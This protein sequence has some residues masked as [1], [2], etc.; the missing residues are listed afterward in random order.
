MREIKGDSKVN[1]REI[2]GRFKG[3]KGRFEEDVK[4]IKGDLKFNL[5]EIRGRFK[6]DSRR[7]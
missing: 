2:Q 6:G 7:I 3:I 5:R 4:E 1:L